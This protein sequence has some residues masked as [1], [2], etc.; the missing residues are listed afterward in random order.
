MSQGKMNA[1]ANARFPI[2]KTMEIRDLNDEQGQAALQVKGKGRV[3]DQ[4]LEVLAAAPATREAI[5]TDVLYQRL[6][7]TW[8]AFTQVNDEVYYSKV[9]EEQVAQ[10]RYQAASV[11]RV[12]ALFEDRVSGGKATSTDNDIDQMFHKAETRTGNRTRNGGGNA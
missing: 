2:A 10:A 3:S 11:D 9:S 7:N 12:A 1:K 8:Y 6:G 4:A 5:E